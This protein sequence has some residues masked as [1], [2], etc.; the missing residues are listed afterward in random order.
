MSLSFELS[1]EISEPYGFNKESLSKIEQNQFVKNQ[2]P[3]V[4]FIQNENTKIAYVGESTNAASRIRDHLSNPERAVLNKISIIGSDKFNKSA[5]LDIESKLIQYI[6]SEG[7]YALQNGNHGLINHNY[8]QQNRYTDLFKAIWERLVDKKIVSKSLVEIENSELFKYSPYK[9][10]N[11]EQYKSVLAI[12]EGLSSRDSNRIFVRG[13]AGTGKTILA[14]YLIKLLGSDVSD[15]NMDDIGEDE[16]REIN[17]IKRYRKKYPNAKIG[18]V[19]AMT[20]L[21]STLQNVFRKVPG[22]K[23]SMVV[24][25]SDTFKEKYDLLIV[26]EAHRLRQFRNIGWMGVFR[27]NNEKLGLDD[28]GN[29]LDWIIANSKNQIFFYDSAQS[30]KPSDIDASRFDNLFKRNTLTIDLTS[31]MRVKGGSNYIRFVDELLNVKRESRDV[32]IANKYELLVFD[33]FKDLTE[34]LRIKEK[35]YGLCRLVAGY[36]W[37]WLSK[38][39]KEAIDIEIEGLGLQWNR[40]DKDWINSVDAFKEVGCIHTTQGYDLNYTGVIFGE[41]IRFNKRIGRIEIDPAKYFDQN[42]KRGITNSED[43]KSYIINIY[44]TIMYR[45]I[46]GTFIYACDRDL[47]EY[48]ASHISKFQPSNSVK[49]SSSEKELPS[50]NSIPLYNL[51]AAAGSFS[52]PQ[53]INQSGWVA[54]PSG[55]KFSRDLFACM[56]L[57]ESMNK[58]IPSGSICLFRRYQGGSRNGKIVLAEHSSIQ[59]HDYGSCYTIKVYHSEKEMGEDGQWRHTT[60]CLKPLSYN[61]E[62]TDIEVIDDEV[63]PVNVIGIFEYVL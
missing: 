63:N 61:S 42:G 1:I 15:S 48:L 27:K 51:K 7:T 20:S 12:L 2:W 19:V 5:T 53:S 57:G 3:L 49:L 46:M 21:R 37:P 34:Q 59:D 24:S 44:K 55:V 47:R 26:D 6:S 45:G 40:T 22:L 32:F 13:S 54:L 17:L 14:S 58:R 35:A 30:V 10:L 36:S 31:Q 39:N 62:F 50:L 23:S 60:I 29:E 11:E 52:E 33:S 25:P 4:Y 9:S 18:M 38:D 56:V 16:L 41:E 28:T 43:L 8:Y